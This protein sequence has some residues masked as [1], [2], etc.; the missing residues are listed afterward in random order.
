M[1][2]TSTTASELVVRVRQ[3]AQQIEEASAKGFKDGAVIRLIYEL[4]HK[5]EE[6]ENEATREYMDKKEAA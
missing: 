1:T 5:V 3:L 2:Y 6:L 4:G